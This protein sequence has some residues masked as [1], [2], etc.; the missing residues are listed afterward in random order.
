MAPFELNEEFFIPLLTKLIGSNSKLQN[1][2]PSGKIPEETIAANHILEAL[3][4]FLK[5]NGGVL[6]YQLVEFVKNRANLI[7]TYPATHPDA[8]K[9][10]VISFIGSHMDVVPYD[11]QTWKK[12]W[13]YYPGEL[14]IEGDLLYGRGTTDCLG[15][16]SLLTD[17]LATLATKK[18]ALK[19]TITVVFIANE[20]YGGLLGVGIDQLGK[21]GY[22]DFMKSGPVYWIDAA[23]SQP[24]IGTCGTTQW[25]LTISGRLFH[26]GLPH[27]GINAV[28]M[29]IDTINYIQSKFYSDFPPHP[30][31]AD[32]KFATQS[33]L[34]PTKF[35]SADS[36]SLNQIPD[37]CVIQGDIRSSPFYDVADIAKKFEEYV[38]EINANPSLLNEFN[39]G[40]HGPHSKYDL[41][42]ENL[43]GKVTLKWV[44]EGENGV[45]CKIDSP[46]FHA[47]VAATEKVLGE[48]KPY[49]IGGSLPLIR[50]LQEDGFDVQ[51]SGYGLSSR[52]HADNEYC[53]LNDLKNA[54][55]IFS[56]IITEYENK[57]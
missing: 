24:C 20:E 41:K 44:A 3:K 51:I 23:D 13:K 56:T 37:H 11:E 33:T 35:K 19:S 54:T 45:A 47:L 50:S 27:K 43:A 26:S 4:P 48:A 25:E 49:S 57:V 18:P 34:K 55:K 53:S 17:L 29:G 30:K 2:P 31:E 16:V 1:A 15:H 8:K 28:E 36:N 46:G 6:E 10:N 39:Q 22:L 9:E 42:E 21:E 14:N 7:L 52:Y 5:E 32:Y 12:T 38:A 40:V